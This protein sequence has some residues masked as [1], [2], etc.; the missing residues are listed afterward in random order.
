MRD[1]PCLL[2][3][4][5]RRSFNESLTGL[6]FPLQPAGG[7]KEHNSKLWRDQPLRW[8]ICSETKKHTNNE[9]ICTSQHSNR[10]LQSDLIT[11]SSCSN[12]SNKIINI[13]FLLTFDIRHQL[14]LS[15]L[16]LQEGV[17][18]RKVLCPNVWQ[19]NCIHSVEVTDQLPETCLTVRTTIHQHRE[20][21]NGEEGT[22]TSA[23]REHVAAGPGELEETHGGRRRQELEGGLW[24]KG[25]RD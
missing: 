9:N 8:V 2:L 5:A 1:I 22:V 16:P 4:C 21:I 18:P 11:S 7:I 12:T 19:Q 23:G 10:W 25:A 14:Q 24:A 6:L 15:H 20:P 13:M 3:Y 17:D